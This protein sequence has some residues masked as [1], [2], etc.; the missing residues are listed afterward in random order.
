MEHGPYIEFDGSRPW[1]DPRDGK[2]GRM[3][4]AFADVRSV[5]L[6]ENGPFYQL[7]EEQ[8][9]HRTQELRERVTELEARLA[10]D[11]AERITEA[12]AE[13]LRGMDVNSS[14]DAP[15]PK[16]TQPQSPRHQHRQKRQHR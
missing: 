3:Y 7:V 14:I 2:R 13:K 10:Q 1:I 12:V 16:N 9:A 6:D 8:V 11:P 5:I 4:W 15:E